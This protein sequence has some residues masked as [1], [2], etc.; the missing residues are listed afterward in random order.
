MKRYVLILAIL[1]TVFLAGCYHSDTNENQVNKSG[2]N[3]YEFSQEKKTS[4]DVLE[5]LPLQETSGEKFISFKY[6]S[7]DDMKNQ[8]IIPQEVKIGEYYD[9]GKIKIGNN[10]YD[11]K[12]VR[13]ENK[14]SEDGTYYALHDV[15]QFYKDNIEILELDIGI[16][17][18]G[19]YEFEP[20]YT[21]EISVFKDKYLV[22]VSTN[23]KGDTLQYLKI[24]DENLADQ[25]YNKSLNQ[26]I[27][28]YFGGIIVSSRYEDY[29]SIQDANII[30]VNNGY[31]ENGECAKITYC[32]SEENGSFKVEILEKTADGYMGDA[33][34]T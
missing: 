33:G 5:D 34:R 8:N 13:E 1:V 19:M 14:D 24:Y 22:T 7:F 31:Y 17:D 11:L 4:G 2:D 12:Y 18:T 32:L 23:N 3:V 30:F 15:L 6:T 9:I 20:D 26:Y 28:S 21:K 27:E 10:I 16:N 25:M 29:Y